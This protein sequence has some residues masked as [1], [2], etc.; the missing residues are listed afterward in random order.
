MLQEG[1][2]INLTGAS[3]LVNL[4]TEGEKESKKTNS[5][6]EYLKMYI[7]K[8]IYAPPRSSTRIIRL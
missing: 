3:F 1:S 2:Y 8:G 7:F 6:A 4:F 5:L